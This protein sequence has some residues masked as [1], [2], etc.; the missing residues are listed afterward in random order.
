M[1]QP[2]V[3]EFAK[4]VGIETLALMD[5]IREWHLPIKSHMAGLDEAMISEIKERLAAEAGAKKGAT[6]KKTKVKKKVAKKK[7][8]TTSVRKVVTAT[9]KAEE[10][11]SP[12]KKKK[13]TTKART[14]IRRKAGEKEEAEA[15]AS[16]SV[17]DREDIAEFSGG[18]ESTQAMVG[19]GSEVAESAEAAFVSGS[20]A[21]RI[22]DRDAED[23][24]MGLAGSSGAEGGT[25]ESAV[26][27]TKTRRNIVG[28]MDLKR[29]VR[30]ARE[31]GGVPGASSGFGGASSGS[32]TGFSSGSTTSPR[33]GASRSLRTGFV[34]PSPYL[35]D[36]PKEETQKE[37][38]DKLKKR[39]GAGKEQPP[40]SFSASEFRKREVVFQPKKKKIPGR[41]EVKKTQITTPKASKRVV[42]FHHV[43]KVGELAGQMN[44]KASQLIKK[45][46]GEGIM[47][48]INT[49]LDFD[50]V[51]LLV[52]EFGF[53]A[54]NVASSPQTLIEEAAFG[55]LSE[56]AVLRTP[57]VTVMGHVD[58]GKTTLLDSIRHADVA[59]REAG[60]ITQ[61]IGAYQVTLEDGSRIT[62]IDTPGHA[63]FTAM[64]ARGANV[65]DIVIIVV[66]AD[67]GVMPQTVEA[68][69]H[70]KAANVPII[71]A[72]NKM[73][74]PGANPDK[75]KQQ[76]TEFELV[77]EEWGGNIIFCPVSALKGEGIKELLEQIRLVAEVQEL[78]ANPQR[79]GTGVVIESRMDK[80]RGCV[81]TLLVKDGTIKSGQDIVVGMVAGRI[82]AMTNDRGEVVKEAGPGEP[83]EIIGLPETP[84]A[85]DQF[86]ITQTEAQAQTI[87]NLRRQEVDAAEA[88]REKPTLDQLFS[89]VK[90]G[91]VKELSVVLKA[92]VAGSLEA[93][94]GMFDKVGTEEV[95][96]KLI[97]SAVGGISESDVLLASA[98]QGLVLGFN[99][100]PDSAA[101]K[102]GKEKKVEI[103][104]YT[105]IYELMDDVTK[106]LSGLLEPEEVE[107][108]LGRA[109]VRNTFSVPKSGVIAGCAVVDGKISR[110]NQLRLVRD[111]KIV[112]QGKVSSLK[113]FKDDVKEVA[114]GFE[115][116]IGI[117]NFN[118]IKVGDVIEAFEVSS[119]AREL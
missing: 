31:G 6:A 105:I 74:K 39:P 40:A 106:A 119:V 88:L 14:V 35:D 48:T 72:V 2:K 8:K 11:A 21:P 4:E 36:S 71:V 114:S 67:D 110:N 84:L 87:A 25:E 109:E 101:Q 37:K 66:A 118:D 17:A 95:K 112:Y 59:S 89:K 116:G 18:F 63:A 13:A 15:M 90:A 73:D 5:K 32:G 34:A 76:L 75:I 81:A 111:G 22:D 23:K 117:E 24:G 10:E 60:G 16:S 69:N 115:C 7:T 47:A 55:E 30:P 113:R 94:K 97:H 41:G 68:I 107:S 33:P 83:V 9:S 99:V 79:S 56:T 44:L 91:A 58:H 98:A 82:R 96:V 27:E 92:D 104:C 45:L 61:H 29:A 93:V 78:K 77:P 100:R 108:S 3:Y 62:F 57:V 42:K 80:G 43:I 19:I 51:A 49:D 50:T 46:M 65:T 12:V 38:D 102:L 64:R 103:K 28:R 85:G 54:Q 52:P 70:A 20:E 53:E 86:D 26:V 1:S